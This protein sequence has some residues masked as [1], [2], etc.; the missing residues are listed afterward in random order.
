MF[1]NSQELQVVINR[2]DQ[3]NDDYALKFITGGD[4]QKSVDYLLE[5]CPEHAA[6]KNISVLEIDIDYETS[7]VYSMCV[8]SD[9]EVDIAIAKNLNHCWKRYTI[10]KELFHILIDKDEARNLNFA[11]HTE[12]VVVSF[13]RSG[14]ELHPSKSVAAE[15]LAE[16]ATM[17]FLF[18]YAQREKILKLNTGSPNYPDIAQFYRIPKVLVEKYLSK[19]FMDG[20]ATVSRRDA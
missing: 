12:E 14:D 10:C 15:M 6:Q 2:A 5:M 17:E 19:Q 20:L 4:P 11:L 8:I 1:I 7:A 16:F 13:P 9:E 18:P 3:I